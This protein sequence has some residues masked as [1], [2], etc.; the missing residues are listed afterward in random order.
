MIQGMCWST[1]GKQLISAAMA[2]QVMIKQMH[3]N[4]SV[5]DM[6]PIDPPIGG[7][8]LRLLGLYHNLGQDVKATYVG[9]YDWP[10]EKYRRHQ[11]SPSLEEINIPLSQEHHLAANEWAVRANGKTV[12]D[13]IFSQQ[14]HLSPDYLAG[15]LENIKQAEVVVFSHPWVYPL[16]DP[17]L[18]QGK[19]V[20]Y[21]SHNIEGYLR[22]QLFDESNAAEL[23]AIRQVIADEYLLGQRA[24]LI[25]ACS[26]ED[27]LRFSRVYEFSVEKCGWCLMV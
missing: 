21:D 7:G 16:I 26:Q 18:L 14:G 12:I 8:R 22:A 3:L 13:V 2:P 1:V 24:D 15:V 10:G 17:S 11:L 27:L 19:V 23:A 5:A 25:L 6:Q 9:S 4:V 20:V